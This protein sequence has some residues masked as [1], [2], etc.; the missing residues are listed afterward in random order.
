M[1]TKPTPTVAQP[2]A[3]EGAAALTSNDV[4]KSLSVFTTEPK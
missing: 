3:D 4:P 1:T 2:A